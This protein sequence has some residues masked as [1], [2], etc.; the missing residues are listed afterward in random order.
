MRGAR[1]RVA[2]AGE[3]G[4]EAIEAVGGGGGEA[5]IPTEEP[6]PGVEIEITPAGKS[7]KRLS[8]PPEARSR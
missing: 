6:L 3:H 5:G 2:P 8:C 7:M 1:R 4:D